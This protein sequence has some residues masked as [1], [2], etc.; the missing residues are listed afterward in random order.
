MSEKS[1]SECS[2]CGKIRV[3]QESG[4]CKKC[5]KTQLELPEPEPEPSINQEPEPEPEPEPELEPKSLTRT[6]I[7]ESEKKYNVEIETCDNCG[8]QNCALMIEDNEEAVL[9]LDCGT[10]WR[11]ENE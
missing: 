11:Y 7:Q 5:E 9:C 6:I 8:S 10:Y 1:K 2:I 3:L 4:M